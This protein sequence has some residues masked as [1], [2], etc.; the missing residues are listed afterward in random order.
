MPVRTSQVAARLNRLIGPYRAMR[1][2]RS[3][4][5]LARRPRS[6]NSPRIPRNT[7]LVIA[8]GSALGTTRVMIADSTVVPTSSAPTTKASTD[9]TVVPTASLPPLAGLD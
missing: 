6:R 7:H 4:K 5:L 1:R 2:S 8:T 3:S 9:S